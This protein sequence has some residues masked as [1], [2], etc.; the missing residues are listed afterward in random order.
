[1]DSFIQ[2]YLFCWTIVISESRQKMF[3]PPD[4]SDEET[5]TQG[6]VIQIWAGQG[7]TGMVRDL[8]PGITGQPE[9]IP[10]EL[11]ELVST[12][13]TG[14]RLAGRSW[15]HGGM[16]LPDSQCQSTD[17]AGEETPHLP[18]HL[19]SALSLI[20]HWPHPASVWLLREHGRCKTQRSASRGQS[21]AEKDREWTSS[22]AGRKGG[23]AQ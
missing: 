13:V 19:P 3:P 22:G 17:G 2:Q 11:L 1:M 18:L 9:V 4:S 6:L 23:P 15:R 20:L 10:A 14:E 8:K 21:R 16:L 7:N 12:V 5:L